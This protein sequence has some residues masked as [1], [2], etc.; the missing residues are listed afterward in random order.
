MP[1]CGNGTLVMTGL[2][3]QSMPRSCGEVVHAGRIAAGVDRAAHQRHRGRHERI[4]A[5]FHDRDGGDDGHGGLAHRQHMDVA[6]QHVQH[7][8][9]VIDV[10]VEIEAAFAQGHH[11][12]IGPIGDVDLMR[13]QQGF[14]RATQQRRVMAGHRRNDQHARLRAAQRTGELAIEVEQ[15]AERLL[16]DRADLDGDADAVGMGQR[17]S[18]SPLLAAEMRQHALLTTLGNGA[19]ENLRNPIHPY[20][21]AT[22]LLMEGDF[23]QDLARSQ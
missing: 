22:G 19:I 15:L 11:A 9:D 23:T 8:D 7:L 16:P 21:T 6:A 1:G 14:D 3:N 10:V 20:L 4:A 2:R 5:R 13:R 17:K 18:R 12:G